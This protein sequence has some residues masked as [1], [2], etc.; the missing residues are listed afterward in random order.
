[1]PDVLGEREQK[2]LDSRGYTY[3]AT[4]ESNMVCLVIKDL[5]LPP[6]YEPEHVDLLL[7]LPL[8]FP[9]V[10]PDMFWTDPPV[11]YIGGVVPPGTELLEAYVGRTWQR[12]SRHF[13]VSNWRP[14]VDDLRSYMQLIRATLDRERLAR[15]A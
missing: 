3:E 10:A 9:D 12:W 8:Q 13:G 15:A 11:R 14:G 2:Y 1:M 7:R 5:P 4:V 6:G